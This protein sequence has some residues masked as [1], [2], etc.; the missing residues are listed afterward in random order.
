MFRGSMDWVGHDRDRRLMM[1]SGR[2]IA[3]GVAGLLGL[4]GVASATPVTYTYSSGDVVIT[5][6][7]LDGESILGGS[8]SPE[9]GLASSSTATIDTQADTLAFLFNQSSAAFSAALAGSFTGSGGATYNLNSASL[10]LSGV[11]L[12]QPTGTTLTLTA[13]GTGGYTFA[14]PSGLTVSGNYDLE[15][16]EVTKNGTTTSFT[17]GV[18]AFGPKNQAFSGSATVFQGNTLQVDGL[19]LGSWTVD[20]QTLNVVGDVI[21]NGVA[22]VPLPASLWMLVSGVGLLGLA[23]SKRLA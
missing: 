9:A 6:I 10:A 3:L 17:S 5:G 18:T 11:Q 19:T 14:A 1:E 21:F 12:S 20:G 4:A 8:S 7:S 13:V 16:L 15:N 22:P 2:L 23:R